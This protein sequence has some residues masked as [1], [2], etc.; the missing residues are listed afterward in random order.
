MSSKTCKKQRKNDINEIAPSPSNNLQKS[1]E[2][3]IETINH[4]TEKYITKQENVCISGPNQISRT[5]S[6]ERGLK[7]QGKHRPKQ[8]KCKQFHPIHHLLQF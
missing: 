4:S 7:F 2:Q 1:E 8:A 6:N 3:Q 5:G